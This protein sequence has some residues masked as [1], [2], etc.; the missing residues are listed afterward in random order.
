[1][2]RVRNHPSG[3]VEP[4]REDYE[5]TQKIKAAC[6]TV[7]IRILDPLIVS[8]NQCFSLSEYNSL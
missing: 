1:L 6:Q 7:S 3:T 2:V 8:E 5:I 4:S